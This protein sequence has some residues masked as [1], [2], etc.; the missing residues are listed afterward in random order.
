MTK[1]RSQTSLCDLKPSSV[2]RVLKE[3]KGEE[4]PLSEMMNDQRRLYDISGTSG[5]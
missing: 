4:D 5:S 1:I 3:Y 2:G